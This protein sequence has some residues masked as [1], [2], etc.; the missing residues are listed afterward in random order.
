M[1]LTRRVTREAGAGPI[2]RHWQ[3]PTSTASASQRTGKRLTSSETS[4]CRVNCSIGCGTKSTLLT[5]KVWDW[6]VERRANKMSPTRRVSLH[7]FVLL[8][9][10]GLA[11]GD[12]IE[13]QARGPATPLSKLIEEVERN[14]PQILPARHGW[15]AATQVSSQVSTLPD[16]QITMQH[17]TVGRPRPLAGYTNIDFS[18]I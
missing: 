13:E 1:S 9:P 5:W 17:C 3:I 4:L 11:A 7:L 2:F 16:P 14:N 8:L 6:P 12:L 18:Y 15:M 10:M